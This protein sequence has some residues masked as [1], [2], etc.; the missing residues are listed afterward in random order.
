LLDDEI[1]RLDEDGA[2]LDD[3][4]ESDE[5][6]VDSAALELAAAGVDDEL[7]PPPQPTNNVSNELDNTSA[8]INRMQTSNLLF[9][10]KRATQRALSEFEWRVCWEMR[11][12]VNP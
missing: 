9:C 12:E 5:A 1:A 6:A 3:T 11:S 2:R 10:L 8:V 4:A 7:P